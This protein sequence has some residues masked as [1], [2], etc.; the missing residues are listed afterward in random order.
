MN[1]NL[2]YFDDEQKDFFLIPNVSIEEA[3]RTLE[4]MS[5][6]YIPKTVSRI[7]RLTSK[8]DASQVSDLEAIRRFEKIEAYRCFEKE[9]SGRS[10][11]RI[12]N[13][14]NVKTSQ[15]NATIIHKLG[16]AELLYMPK[17]FGEYLE[18]VRKKAGLSQ[19][20]ATGLLGLAHSSL[21]RYESGE[22]FPT[23]ASISQFYPLAKSAG[24]NSDAIKREYIVAKYGPEEGT[25]ADILGR[26]RWF[27]QMN[28]KRLAEVS[29]VSS[30]FIRGIEKGKVEIGSIFWMCLEKL[31]LSLS[32]ARLMKMSKELRK[33]WEES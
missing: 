8:G 15:A 28:V 33:D 1:W 23:I 18:H 6:A 9:V 12:S 10:K 3:K 4:A 22:T 27:A 13:Y 29:G 19:K 5:P 11:E 2:T 24:L 21:A 16:M 7:A 14:C 26:E 31:A 32:S 25:L 17:S 20:A 30:S